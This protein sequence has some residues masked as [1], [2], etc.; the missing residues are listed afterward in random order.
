[1]KMRPIGQSGIE[2]SVVAFGAWAIGGWQWGGTDRRAA[3]RAIHAAVDAGMNLIDTAPVYGFGRSEEITGEAIHDR[4]SRVVLATKAGLVWH[5]DQGDPRF[6]TKDPLSGREYSVRKYLGPE[7]IRYEIEQS[8]RRLKT[9][10]IDL[11]QTHRQ[12]TTTPIEDTMETL[13]RLKD[14]GKIRAIGV[15]NATPA[16]MDAYRA[17]GIVDSDQEEYNMLR[18]DAEQDLLPYC[19]QNDI[20]FLAYSPIAQ[21]LLTGKV[22]PDREFAETDQRS[23]KELFSV[24]NRRRVADMLKRFQPIADSHG[25]TLTQL[26]VAWTVHQPGC[27]HALVGARNEEQVLENA[28]GGDVSLSGADLN[29]MQSAVDEYRS[30]K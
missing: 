11:Y 19:A 5:T 10:Y 17:V 8:L 7:S 23:T 21:G 15:S 20:A 24:E 13:N 6:H 16:Q 28:A 4:R 9:D 12:E 1:M 3:V 22:G 30:Q 29:V 14:E 18:P 26:A 2:A 25:C 27:T